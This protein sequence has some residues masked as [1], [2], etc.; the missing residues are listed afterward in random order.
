MW[1]LY[2]DPSWADPLMCHKWAYTPQ[3]LITTLESAVFMHARQA[4]AMFKLREPRDMRIVA[5]KLVQ[6]L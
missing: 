3:T 4:K 1:P 2:G 6:I 5:E